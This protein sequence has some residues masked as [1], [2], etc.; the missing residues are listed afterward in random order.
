[1]ARGGPPKA[2][3]TL[4]DVART[5]SNV[6]GLASGKSFAFNPILARRTGMGTLVSAASALLPT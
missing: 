6:K 2:M 3:K 5:P 1:M 4:G